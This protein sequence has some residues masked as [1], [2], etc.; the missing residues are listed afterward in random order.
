MVVWP[1]VCSHLSPAPIEHEH[2]LLS[3]A[4]AVEYDAPLK[5]RFLSLGA[6]IRYSLAKNIILFIR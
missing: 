4:V 5:P 3:G 6:G 1:A 2:C